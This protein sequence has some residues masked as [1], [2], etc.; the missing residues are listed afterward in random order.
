[1]KRVIATS[2]APAVKASKTGSP[3]EGIVPRNPAMAEPAKGA[4]MRSSRRVR[5]KAMRTLIPAKAAAVKIGAL[6]VSRCTLDSNSPSSRPPT[7][8][9]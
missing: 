9:G 3:S 7:M 1:M 5:V 2:E 8:H 4:G 6:L